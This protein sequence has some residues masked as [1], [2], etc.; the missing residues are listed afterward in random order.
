MAFV[1]RIMSLDTHDELTA[2]WREIIRAGMPPAALAALGDMSAI[3]YD[4]MEAIR[5][6]L[7]SKDKVDEIRLAKTL[8][9]RFR[10]QYRRAG[11][12]ARENAR[13]GMAEPK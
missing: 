6:T 8:A 4:R 9:A 12:I 1:I 5:R 3:G 13:T 10:E 7:N 2:A 11:E